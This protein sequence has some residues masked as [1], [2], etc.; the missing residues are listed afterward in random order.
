MD[1]TPPAC[2]THTQQHVYNMQ[3]KL[4]T[5]THNT[6]IPQILTTQSQRLIT[7]KPDQ[8]G[9]NC[10]AVF[11]STIAGETNNNMS[12]ITSDLGH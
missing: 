2:P 8:S 3:Q 12:T 5:A 11:E 1:T 10:L 4:H 9:A 7:V 6:H